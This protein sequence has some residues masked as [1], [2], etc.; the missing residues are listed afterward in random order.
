MKFY[1]FHRKIMNIFSILVDHII[2]NLRFFENLL[3]NLLTA[4]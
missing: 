2:L 4:F 1:Y 3:I